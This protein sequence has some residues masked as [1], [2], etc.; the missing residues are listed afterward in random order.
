MLLIKPNVA[1]VAAGTVLA[2]VA[3]A[4]RDAPVFDV[5]E[6][7]ESSACCAGSAGGEE[8][9]A[10]DAGYFEF[11]RFVASTGNGGGGQE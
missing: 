6:P 3:S 10:S 2:G 11:V 5:E 4:I 7:G 8:W 1:A 9:V